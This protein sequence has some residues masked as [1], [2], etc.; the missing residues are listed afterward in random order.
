MKY[1]KLFENFKKNN[2]EGTLIT[3]EDVIECIKKNG[4]IYTNIIHNYPNNDP[5]TGLKPVD[6][7]NDGL[8]TVEI[9]NNEY[10]VDL[11]DLTKIEFS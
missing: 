5:E 8:I 1:I 4:L 11:E 7:D 6:I 10:T 9:E 3:K 2:Q